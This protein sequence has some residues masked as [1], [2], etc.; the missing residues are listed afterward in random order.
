VAAAVQSA[1][2]RVY[3]ARIADVQRAGNDRYNEL[4]DKYVETKQQADLLT[5]YVME[6]DGKMMQ[7]KI[8]TPEESFSGRQL[9]RAKAQQ[10]KEK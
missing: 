1:Q 4:H 6:F 2:Q 9:Q 5:Y 8:I 7:R 3:E 10:Q